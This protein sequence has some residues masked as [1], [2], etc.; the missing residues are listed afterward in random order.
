MNQQLTE[1]KNQS[2]PSTAK[3]IFL[4]LLSVITLYGSVIA[5]VTILFQLINIY[6]PDPASS[7]YAIEGAKSSIRFSISALVVMFPIYI[8]SVWYLTKMRNKDEWNKN[9]KVRS[10]LINFTLF[11]GA[12]VL[13]ITLISLINSFLNGELTLRFGLKLLSLAAVV[14]SVFYYY[15]SLAKRESKEN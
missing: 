2:K 6:L 5:L 7:R 8:W 3:D 9:E 1:D 11:V 4:H 14:G 10:W 12:I 13:I 15:L